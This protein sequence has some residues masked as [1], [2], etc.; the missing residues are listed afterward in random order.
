MHSQLTRE[1]RCQIDALVSNGATQSEIAAILQ[2]HPSTVCCELQRN[3]KGRGKGYCAKEA[4]SKTDG[5]RRKPPPRIPASAKR[6][7]ERLMREK[8]WTPQAISERLK[9]ERGIQVGHEWICQ[10]TLADQAKGGDLH[11]LLSGSR[12]RWKRRGVPKTRGRIPDRTPIHERPAKAND[13]SET[14]HW[15]GDTV[16]GAKHKDVIVT[17][18][19]RKSRFLAAAVAGRKT[20]AQVSDAMM[21]CMRK[22]KARCESITFDNGR[23]TAQ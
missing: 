2:V 19:E 21:R 14:G 13:R 9:L 17:L 22:H 15:Q 18:A 1:K 8:G 12:K 7:V 16:V 5:R 10:M 20:K 6:E 23:G 11:R 3:A 4:Q